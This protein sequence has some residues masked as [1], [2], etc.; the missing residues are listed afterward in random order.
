VLDLLSPQRGVEG[1]QAHRKE[2]EKALELKSKIKD[3]T[4]SFCFFF[5]LFL[6]LPAV[7]SPLD[8]LDLS[9]LDPTPSKPS[10]LLTSLLI[11]IEPFVPSLVPLLSPPRLPS[12]L[13]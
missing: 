1:G 3:L 7:L 9:R 6:R 11:S 4:F 13:F 2:R 12:R 8:Q 5:L 10:L